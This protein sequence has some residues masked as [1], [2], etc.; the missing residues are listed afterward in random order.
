MRCSQLTQLRSRMGASH[1]PRSTAIKCVPSA[2]WGHRALPHPSARQRV[3]LGL[4]SLASSK[5]VG[6]Y[7]GTH[8]TFLAE[9]APTTAQGALT[10][11][12]WDND[13]PSGSGLDAI[14]LLRFEGIFGTGAGQIPA[15]ATITSATLGYQVH[16]V[17]HNANLYR[18]GIAWDE[19]ATYSGFGA[20]PGV[21]SEDL[22][23]LV[24]T[25]AGN[26]G[27]HQIDVTSSVAGWLA[28]P[29]SN[30]GWL[31]DPTN[32]NGVDVWSSEAPDPTLRPSLT[33]TFLPPAG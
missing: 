20:S 17:G 11:F 23:G 29:T 13:D 6:G 33:V 8:D 22:A 25:V 18:V 16:N 30:H 10:S 21:Q 32:T 31:W 14:A 24:A 7:A 28:D 26:T 19:G 2:A 1:H 27:S 3:Q 9:A 12:G 5:G 4:R 15:G